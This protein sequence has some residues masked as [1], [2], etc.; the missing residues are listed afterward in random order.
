M[1]EDSEVVTLD[2]VISICQKVKDENI[3]IRRSNLE[4][5]KTIE[6]MANNSLIDK[7]IFAEIRKL[8]KDD[9]HSGPLQD[10]N[11]LN[12]HPLWVFIKQIQKVKVL[13]YIK[14]KIIN[15][16]RKVIVYSF[17][18]EGLHDEKK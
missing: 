15:H 8:T 2:E 6:F 7:D 1:T 16:K 13:V 5:T 17:H 12:K 14:I 18:E 9:Y 10:K 4:N 3:E 11:L